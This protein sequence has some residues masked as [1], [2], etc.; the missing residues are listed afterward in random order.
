MGASIIRNLLPYSIGNRLM[1]YEGYLSSYEDLSLLLSRWSDVKVYNDIDFSSYWNHKKDYYSGSSDPHSPIHIGFET[2]CNYSK[3]KFC[4]FKQLPYCSF[5]SDASISSIVDNVSYLSS[6]YNTSVIRLID[7]LFTPSQKKVEILSS[8]RKLDLYTICYSSI[9]YLAKLSYI[10]FLNL[11]TRSLLIGL[12]STNDYSLRAVGKGYTYDIIKKAISNI[13]NKLS[14]RISLNFSIMLDL[15]V[16]GVSEIKKNYDNIEKIK[17]DL[18]SSGF[19]VNMTYHPLSLSDNKELLNTTHYDCIEYSEEY[20]CGG[21]WVNHHIG[22]V[23]PN[24]Q[25]VPYIRRD[26]SGNPIK[27]DIIYL[28]N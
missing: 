18:I 22:Q 19:K 8:L 17:A 2:K 21:E 4:T 11:C 9:P 3:C 16:G 26:S 28:M 15:P 7:S 12:E 23:I 24:L 14:R 13:K 25:Y 5:I 1:V 20:L 10:E 6:Y 27:S